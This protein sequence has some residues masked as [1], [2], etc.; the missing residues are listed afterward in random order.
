M[1]KKGMVI[2]MA[3]FNGGTNEAGHKTFKDHASEDIDLAFFNESEHADRHTIDG[4]ECLVVL[5]DD[6]LREHGAHWEA[7]AKQNFDTGLYTAHAILYIK[8]KDYGAK[9]KQ[10]KLLVVDKGERMQRTFTIIKCE[11]D[12]GVYRMTMERTRH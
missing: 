11:E 12:A 2:G 9:P 10:G 5:E 8:V 1:Q 7:G 4:K 3:L 6:D